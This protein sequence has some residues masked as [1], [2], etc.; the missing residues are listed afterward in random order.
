MRWLSNRKKRPEHGPDDAP[1]V[2]ERLGR[3]I[4]GAYRPIFGGR[5]VPTN[6]GEPSEEWERAKL[7]AEEMDRRQARERDR[8]YRR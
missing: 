8:N 3:G 7:E 6:P 1:T 5:L 2:G 4:G